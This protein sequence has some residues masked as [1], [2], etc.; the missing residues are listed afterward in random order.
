MEFKLKSEFIALDNLLKVL[1][2]ASGGPEAKEIILSGAIKVNGEAETRVRRKLHSGD[3][4]EF[5]QA[6]VSII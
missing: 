4:V 3:R 6:K 5:G 1:E 2:F